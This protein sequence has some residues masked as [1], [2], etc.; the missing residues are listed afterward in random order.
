MNQYCPRSELK[1][2]AKKSLTGNYRGIIVLVL[3]VWLMFVPIT[4]FQ[5]FLEAL[6]QQ[7]QAG[8]SS[9]LGDIVLYL[10]SSVFTALYGLFSIGICLVHLKIACKQL[11]SLYDLWYCF[12]DGH[13]QKAFSVSFLVQL[14]EVICSLPF[15]ICAQLFMQNPSSAMGSYMIIALFI[16]IIIQLPINLALSMSYFIMLDFPE[17]GVKEILSHSIRLMKGNKGRLFF[18]EISFLPLHLLGICS[19]GIGYLWLTPYINMT[20]TLF[21]LDLMNP[22]HKNT[23]VM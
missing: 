16:G 1:N 2:N 23:S 12:R 22:S 3:F 5:A 4:Y 20:H 14:P 8:R 19:M 9:L 7:L 11:Y 21:F 10:L 13:F 6:V 17:Y 18:I 15:V